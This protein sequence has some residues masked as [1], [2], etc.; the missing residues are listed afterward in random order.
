M[1]QR[2][3]GESEVYTMGVSNS[4]NSNKTS[5][6]VVLCLAAIT[7]AGIDGEFKKEE[8]DRLRSLAGSDDKAIN[9]A[10]EIYNWLPTSECIKIV[11][12][13]L[14]EQQKKI[15]FKFLYQYSHHD[16]EFHHSEQL[17]LK[18]Y[19]ETF[20]FSE[21]TIKELMKEGLRQEELHLFN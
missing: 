3:G 13:S 12:N 4:S 14:T 2:G 7:L 20:G 16:N 15:A 21:A 5:G 6:K 19:A 9:D 10:L 11:A 17:L 18:Q 1:N 8:I